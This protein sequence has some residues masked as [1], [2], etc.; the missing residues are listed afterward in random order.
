MHSICTV[1][2]NL[3]VNIGSKPGL[4]LWYRLF[5][6]GVTVSKME[7]KLFQPKNGLPNTTVF[8]NSF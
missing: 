4:L 5:N 6:A 8:K 3:D 2:N 7:E 1:L